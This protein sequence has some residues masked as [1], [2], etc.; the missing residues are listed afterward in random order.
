M[1]DLGKPFTEEQIREI[2]RILVKIRRTEAK[3]DQAAPKILDAITALK[4]FQYFDEQS[5]YLS[6]K[7]TRA[8]KKLDL[9]TVGP[10]QA[11]INSRIEELN[12]LADTL[13][14]LGLAKL[15]RHERR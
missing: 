9:L 8:E 1:N 6:K 11:E 3:T 7:A 15:S 4:I 13:E 12:R 14:E 5:R 10:T 2:R